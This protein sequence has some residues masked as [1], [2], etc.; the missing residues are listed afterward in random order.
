MR[1]ADKVIITCAITGGVHTPT[2]SRHLPITAAQIITQSLDAVEAGAAILHL[3]ARDPET[4]RPSQDPKHFMA[5]LPQI[6]QATDAVV[7]ITTGGGLGMP[8]DER[9]APA[10]LAKPEIASLNMG[11]MN[12]GIFKLAERYTTW[13]HDW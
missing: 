10:L 7:N 6:H 8:L 3:H 11:S 9:L 13:K 2:M 5:F 12:F 1:Q 4:G